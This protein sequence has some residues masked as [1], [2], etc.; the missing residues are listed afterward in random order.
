MSNSAL[1]VAPAVLDATQDTERYGGLGGVRQGP[2]VGSRAVRPRWSSV[3][4]LSLAPAINYFDIYLHG[5]PLGVGGVEAGV[6]KLIHPV[7][8]RLLKPSF[9]VLGLI[10]NIHLDH[11]LVVDGEDG[12]CT[13]TRFSVLVE[14][15]KG[16]FF[17]A[18]GRQ[19]AVAAALDSCFREPPRVRILPV[20]V[21][22]GERVQQRPYTR[23]RVCGLARCGSLRSSGGPSS[24]SPGLSCPFRS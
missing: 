12:C 9:D 6:E 21:A 22:Q 17:P 10:P 5:Y 11:Y 2:R 14:E 24:G 13:G 1:R 23:F 20:S 16:E 18:L 8:H 19:G 4:L 3:L 15:S 7:D